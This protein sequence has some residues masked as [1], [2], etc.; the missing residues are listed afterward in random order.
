MSTVLCFMPPSPAVWMRWE[1]PS[2]RLEDTT[3]W[4]KP[5]VFSEDMTDL[6]FCKT[7]QTTVRR[8]SME[9]M[10]DLTFCQSEQTTV[11]RRSMDEGKKYQAE[12][13]TYYI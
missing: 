1:K 12:K 8:R 2:R 9:D 5:L 4:Q 10:I 11:R 6:T 13:R 7:E 3:T